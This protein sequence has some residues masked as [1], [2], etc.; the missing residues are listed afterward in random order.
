MHTFPLM[1]HHNERFGTVVM[2]DCAPTV[3]TSVYRA[4]YVSPVCV[5]T[6]TAYP[7]SPNC[8]P[9]GKKVQLKLEPPSPTP[10]DE[11][12]HVSLCRREHTSQQAISSPFCGSYGGICAQPMRSMHIVLFARSSWAI[13]NI[14][15]FLRQ[16]EAHSIVQIVCK[17]IRR[18]KSPW[19][20]A[21]S[22]RLSVNSKP[23]E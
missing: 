6:P 23:I 9:V 20:S 17:A 3:C 16:L 14:F 19:H 11:L 21:H 7:S 2:H 10:T 15:P 12:L 8:Q 1:I 13:T 22:V 5:D 4:R 18:L